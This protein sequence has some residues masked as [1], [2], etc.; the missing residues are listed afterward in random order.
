MENLEPVREVLTEARA[1]FAEHHSRL[2]LDGRAPAVK[3]PLDWRPEIE[4]IEAALASGTEDYLRDAV[5]HTMHALSAEVG[6]QFESGE[7]ARND[8][9]QAKVKAIAKE[10]G[11]SGAATRLLDYKAA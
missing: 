6:M 7:Y 5:L 3:V 10:R 4:F 1:F 2:V 9:L 11:W 8:Q